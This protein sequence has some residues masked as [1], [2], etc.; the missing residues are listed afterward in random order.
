MLGQVIMP[1]KYHQAVTSMSDA[2]IHRFLN[3]DRQSI[4]D[5]IDKLPSHEKFSIN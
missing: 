1:K 4:N 3:G 2:E 5:A